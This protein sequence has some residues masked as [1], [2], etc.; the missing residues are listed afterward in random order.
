MLRDIRVFSICN[1]N[2]IETEKKKNIFPPSHCHLYDNQ[3]NNFFLLLQI[4]GLDSIQNLDIDRYINQYNYD[5][6]FNFV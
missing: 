5:Q 3:R 6:Y 1:Q 2:K 4:I